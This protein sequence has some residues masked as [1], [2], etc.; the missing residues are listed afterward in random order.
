MRQDVTHPGRVALPGTHRWM[1]VLLAVGG[2]QLA[3][4]GR[5]ADHVEHEAPAHVEHVAGSE[6][7]RVTLTAKAMERLDVQA[8]EVRMALAPR[9]GMLRKIVPYA[10][11]LYDPNGGTWVYSVPE[12]NTFV[13]AEIVVDYI[14]GDVAVL[15]EGPPVG[16][17]V[18]T[19]G[20]MELFGTEFEVGH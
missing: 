18:V 11:V 13:R 14:E 12:P 15:T 10:A 19:V 9:S 1:V 16:T 8:A 3:A 5:Q 2:L 7:S 4:C 20:G 17:K 6:I